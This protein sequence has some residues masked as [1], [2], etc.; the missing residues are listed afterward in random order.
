MLIILV[1]G[2]SS[3]IGRAC[4]THLLRQGHRV[5]G[6]SR[7]VSSAQD[8]GLLMLPMDVD[9]DASVQAGVAQVLSRE[10]RLDVVINSA[11]YGLAGSV[12]DTSLEEAKAQ[13]E[14]NLFGVV[15]VC[16]AVLPAM[17]AQKS[18]HI[19]IIGSLAGRVGLP[20]QG[21]YSASKFALEGLAEA[22][23]Y[24]VRPF[25]IHVSLVE[26]GDVATAFTRHRHCARRALADSAYA[27]R[28]TSALE[29]IEADER[30]GAHPDQVAR[31]VAKIIA[32]PTPRLRYTAGPMLQ[33]LMVALKRF[34]PYR[35]FEWGL[36]RY[37]RVG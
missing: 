21:L 27:E 36:A 20:F 9:D 3:G 34:I 2:A 32:S 35:L 1:T 29:V 33:R 12:E 18:G 7:H 16:R 31:L 17:R 23:R 15:R 5:Y 13:F 4:A 22:L 11:G 19:L 10:G 14:T 28:F 25:G 6:T 37:Y 30:Q 24:E 8:D 26:P